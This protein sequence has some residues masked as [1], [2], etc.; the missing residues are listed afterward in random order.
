MG[1]SFS[2]TNLSGNHYHQ[3]IPNLYIGDRYSIYEPFFA[4]KKLLVI[5]ATN[6]V[7]FNKKLKSVNKRIAV[8]DDLS[9]YS[10]QI[11]YNHLHNITDTIKKYLD[12]NF[13]VLVHCVAGRQRSCSIV[14]GYLM[15]YHKMSMA[16][17]IEL[18][19]H[20]RPYAFFLNINFKKSLVKFNKTLI[21]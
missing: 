21:I 2:A 20:K 5:N 19:K 12:G 3:I 10:N 11:L 15:K 7:G 13:I 9:S 1:N 18:I 6:D 4:N 8:D 16:K 14:A 17:S